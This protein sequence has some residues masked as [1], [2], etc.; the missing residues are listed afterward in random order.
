MQSVRHTA[1]QPYPSAPRL[2]CY[3]PGRPNSWGLDRHGADDGALPSESTASP[4]R[5]QMR[6][7][8]GVTTPDSIFAAG[9]PTR[10][11]GRLQ[12]AA[13]VGSRA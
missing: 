10:G 6:G 2:K 11:A 9:V 5:R 4:M 13:C 7:R 3:L 8:I 12:G 1:S